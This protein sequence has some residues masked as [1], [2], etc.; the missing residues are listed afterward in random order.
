MNNPFQIHHIGITVRDL[1]RSAEFYGSLFNLEEFARLEMSGPLFE[2]N[3]DVPGA[4]IRVMLMRSAN[5]ILEFVQYI[6]PEGRTFEL[7]NCDIGST[8]VCF[9]VEDIGV[10][11]QELLAKGIRTNGPP[12]DPIPDGPAAGSRFMYFRDPDG[13]TVEVL[14][15]GAGIRC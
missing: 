13:V 5:T 3:V 1:D 6:M 15:P 12:N 4:R 9:P 7:R 2:Q 11:Y 8:H 10:F 14:Q